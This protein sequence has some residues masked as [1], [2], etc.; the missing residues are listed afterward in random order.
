V[1]SRSQPPPVHI[2]GAV[3]DDQP[4]VL[5]PAQGE[6]PPVVTIGPGAT[7]V[8]FR[9]TALSFS[10]PDKVR[11]RYRLEGYEENW[12]SAGTT[13]E[14]T[15]TR[16]PAGAY[17]FRVT[18]IN[19]DGVSNETGAVLAVSVTPPW[20]QTTWFRALTIIALAGFVFGLYE[21]RVYQH[22]KARTM[23][24]AFA[25]RLIESQEQERKRVAGELHDSLG[26]SL[27]II[28][29]RAQLGLDR[30]GDRTESAKH[31]EEISSAAS[32]AIQEVRA[33]SHALRPAELDQL[34]LT[35]AI[36]WM[37]EKAGATS[38]TRF[39][40]ELEPVDGVLLPE[41]EISL[42]RIAQEGI[43]NVLKHAQAGE[44]ILELK[45]AANTV[46]LSIFD[47]GRG[48]AKGSDFA[49]VAKGRVGQGLAGIAERVRLLGG[50]LDLQSALGRGTRLTVTCKLPQNNA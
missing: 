29:G 31:F 33:I 37:V 24:E 50:E 17:R 22:K 40:C 1:R 26:Q 16:L 7:H 6:E 49:D 38:S 27:Q 28:K 13:R 21:L 11:F 44:A 43:N 2:E 42:Y 4:L 35:K 39:A 41:V 23:Q 15:Y 8:G 10:A 30:T 19:N 25:R 32:Q 36:Q 48:F 5:Q 20:W 34:G 18:A 45:R 46:R 3:A 12:V 14:A 47:N 9:Y